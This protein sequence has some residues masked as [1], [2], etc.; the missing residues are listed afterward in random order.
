MLDPDPVKYLE[1]SKKHKKMR[2]NSVD[3]KDENLENSKK[4]HNRISIFSLASKEILF[5]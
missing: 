4:Y 3:N 5:N 1:I 2:S